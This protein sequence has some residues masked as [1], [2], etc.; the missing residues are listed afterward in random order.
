M[1]KQGLRYG[2]KSVLSLQNIVLRNKWLI[3]FKNKAF[4]FSINRCVSV[5]CIPGFTHA[6]N[7]WESAELSKYCFYNFSSAMLTLGDHKIISFSL[8]SNQQSYFTHIF[9][10]RLCLIMT[11][12]GLGALASLTAS[13]ALLIHWV[14]EPQN[15]LQCLINPWSRENT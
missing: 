6:I 5:I 9:S 15:Y 10:K 8:I 4:Y 13:T 1:G 7:L 3:D 2:G 11:C 14:W 12:S